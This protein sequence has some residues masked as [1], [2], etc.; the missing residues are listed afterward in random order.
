MRAHLRRRPI[1]VRFCVEEKLERAGAVPPHWYRW[2]VKSIREYAFF[3]TDLKNRVV[4]WDQGAIDLFGYARADVVGENAEFIFTPED[5]K[6]NAPQKEIALAVGNR[7]AP[8]ERW[9]VKKDGSVF[10]ATGLM[11]TIT[12]DA[13]RHVGF[14]KIV[15]QREPPES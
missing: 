5:I 9:H 14:M 10:W 8:D 1:Y 6:K 11:M 7:T 12:D 13:G 3:T 4:T 2:A 15:R